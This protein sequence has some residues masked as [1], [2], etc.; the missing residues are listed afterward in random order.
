MKTTRHSLAPMTRQAGFTI[1]E[2]MV[3]VA[4][5]LIVILGFTLTFVSMK[6]S[7]VS[8]D[9]S[10][11][12]QDNER[13]AMSILTGAGQQAGYFPSPATLDSTQITAS[14]STTYGGMS[15]GQAVIGTTVSGTTPESVSL[16]FA[17]SANDGLITC[18]G[19]TI[20]AADI[21]AAP[22]TANGSVGVRNTFY[23]DT[24]AKTLNCI[25]QVN[26]GTSSTYG[27]GTAQPLVT[28]VASMSVAYGVGGSTSVTGYWPASGVSDWTAVKAVRITLNFVNPYDATATIPWVQTI[29]LMNR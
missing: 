26:G 14:T 20:T 25:V 24:A 23:V 9:K 29:N 5:S 7:F 18:Q 16:A 13:L 19:H 10:A 1:V 11:Q 21:T 4:I 2:M 17:A 12:L 6:Q 15:A 28:N 22:S 3:A 8:Q 27:G